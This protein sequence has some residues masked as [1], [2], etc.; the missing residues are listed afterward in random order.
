MVSQCRRCQSFL[1]ASHLSQECET[2]SIRYPSRSN[3]QSTARATNKPR[4]SRQS[5]IRHKQFSLK[6][7][8]SKRRNR[9]QSCRKIT[10]VLNST[11]IK[12]ISSSRKS[13]SL[14][15]AITTIRSRRYTTMTVDSTTKHATNLRDRTE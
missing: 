5:S 4:N 15:Q 2:T 8:N 11:K 12:L 1:H 7:S 9:L 3:Q 14:S 13:S 6:S 10:R